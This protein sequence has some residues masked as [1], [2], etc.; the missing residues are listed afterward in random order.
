MKRSER[1]ITRTKYFQQRSKR[2]RWVTGLV[3]RN[4]HS[5]FFFTI[6][7]VTFLHHKTFESPSFPPLLSDVVI[8]AKQLNFMKMKQAQ[9]YSSVT[10]CVTAPRV[11]RE[12]EKENYEGGK[13]A[14]GKVVGSES[15]WPAEQWQV[16][17][18]LHDS[19]GRMHVSFCNPLPRLIWQ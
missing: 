5:V 3:T 18:L 13:Y 17:L 1:F 4:L 8:L 9:R 15:R 10:L 11:P 19:R 2:E 7:V 6:A 16:H 12:R 14:K